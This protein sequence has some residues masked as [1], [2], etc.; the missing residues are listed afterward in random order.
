MNHWWKLVLSAYP[1]RWRQEREDEVL[2][3]LDERRPRGLA[4]VSESAS[5]AVGGLR[6]RG[7]VAARSVGATLAGGVRGAATL[8]LLLNVGVVIARATVDE[9]M[10]P[11]TSPWWIAYSVVTIAAV[12]LLLIGRQRAAGAAGLVLVAL[13]A[14]D[15]FGLFDWTIRIEDWS[16]DLQQWNQVAGANSSRV[17]AMQLDWI[18]SLGAAS[19]L[20]LLLGHRSLVDRRELLVRSAVGLG[21][22]V[23]IG[24][25]TVGVGD[26]LR[27]SAPALWVTLLVLAGA[28][29]LADL[30]PAVAAAAL[31]ALLLPAYLGYLQHDRSFD[32]KNVSQAIFFVSMGLAVGV[33]ATVHARRTAAVRR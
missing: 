7:D 29:W 13:L 14:G 23:L 1:P 30:R 24:A 31:P 28:L 20:L 32:T 27:W 12:V 9:P 16:I 2:D 5:L 15:R 4:V 18:V 8:V 10:I 6:T 25:V 33:I 3:L 26:A 19:S 17:P 11:T 22:I 21:A